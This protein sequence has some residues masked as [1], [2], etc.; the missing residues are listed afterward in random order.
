MV[1]ADAIIS[2][3]PGGQGVAA[4]EFEYVVD[5]RKLTE[6]RELAKFPPI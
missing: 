3:P 6:M 1:P 5:R 4:E 2:G